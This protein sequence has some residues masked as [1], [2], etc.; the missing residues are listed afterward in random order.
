MSQ[1]RSGSLIKNLL[2]NMRQSYSLYTIER[3]TLNLRLINLR[4]C[5]SGYTCV[6]CSVKVHYVLPFKMLANRVKK[7]A[8]YFS[9]ACFSVIYFYLFILI[10]D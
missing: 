5:D 6:V 2:A 3:L 10:N 1:K 7:C 9:S 4:H 8:L